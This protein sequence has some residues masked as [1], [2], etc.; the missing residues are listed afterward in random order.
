MREI[1]ILATTLLPLDVQIAVSSGYQKPSEGTPLNF[2]TK[3]NLFVIR[4]DPSICGHFYT[5]Y[6]EDH[7]TSF[8]KKYPN[9]STLCIQWVMGI[10]ID[11]VSM[12]AT[13]LE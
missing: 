8:S 1:P 7:S 13:D 9:S 2:S 3:G 11:T 4:G 12:I 6:I 10:G 5:P